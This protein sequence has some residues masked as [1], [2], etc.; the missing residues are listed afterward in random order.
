MVFNDVHVVREQLFKKLKSGK[1]G[2]SVG[3]IYAWTAKPYKTL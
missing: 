2:F 1:I 3:N